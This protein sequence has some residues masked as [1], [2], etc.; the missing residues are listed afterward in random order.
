M[1]G[2]VGAVYTISNLPL[3]GSKLNS[4]TGDLTADNTVLGENYCKVATTV[5]SVKPGVWYL[6]ETGRNDRHSADRI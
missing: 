3:Y 5:E 2:S 4:Y 1:R 6:P